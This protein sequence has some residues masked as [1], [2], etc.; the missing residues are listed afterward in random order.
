MSS[1]PLSDFT[2]QSLYLDTMIFYIFL[3]TT[4]PAAKALF[5]QIETGDI[6]AYT[7][8]LTFDEL[9]YRLLLGLIRD[10]Y[11]GSPLEKLRAEEKSMLAEFSPQL[12][13]L[14][15]QLLAYVHLQPVDVT[16]AD[17]LRMSE[18]MQQHHLRPRDALHLAAMQTCGC[19]ALLSHD[20]DF[21]HVPDIQRYHLDLSSGK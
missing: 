21:D 18:Y 14:L 16:T 15:K 13:P 20:A 8:V 12:A 3:R 9:T 1:Q 10:H 2:G 7:S 4:E 6:H 19:R 5:A 17:V 11:P